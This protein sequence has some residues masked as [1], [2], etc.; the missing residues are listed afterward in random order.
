MR[1]RLDGRPVEIK[2]LLLMPE[3]GEW[4]VGHKVAMKRLLRQI[5]SLTL[6]LWRKPSLLPRL[7][8]TS[9]VLRKAFRA[10]HDV[11]K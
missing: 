6:L 10:G 9:D 4:S 2:L 3:L 1:G 11:L 5:M 7:W 8:N